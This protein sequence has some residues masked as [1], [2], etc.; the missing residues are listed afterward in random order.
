[1]DFKMNNVE[2]ILSQTLNLLRDKKTSDNFNIFTTLFNPYDE[3]R[4]HSR[5]IGSLLDPAPNSSHGMGSVFLKLFLQRI[6]D[7][8]ENGKFISIG[9]FKIDD[10]LMRLEWKNIDILLD[11]RSS[12]SCIIIEN[13]I[14]ASDQ[15]RQLYR[16]H[17]TMNSLG[18]KN[19]GILYLTIDGSEPSR[20]S[21]ENHNGTN[22][23]PVCIS[24][25]THILNWLYDCIGVCID[26]PPL[27]ESISQYIGVVK[28]ITGQEKESEIVKK[29]KERFLDED[30]LKAA[31]EIS[32]A[33]G[34]YKDEI[35]KGFLDQLVN[36]INEL[37]Q[38]SE[39]QC[40][41]EKSDKILGNRT[42]ATLS[43]FCNQDINL[44]IEL[45]NGKIF[46]GF[47]RNNEHSQVEVFLKDFISSN[48]WSFNT[49]WY[50][51]KWSEPSVNLSDGSA[52]NL[53]SL[54][55]ENIVDQ[56]LEDLKVSIMPLRKRR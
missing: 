17:Q 53:L 18:R 7:T 4:L 11:C 51:W 27:R 10:S 5:F 44:N 38:D 52:N 35:V 2:N 36:K 37:S 26:N 23:E 46:Y 28:L 9:T 50:G 49:P 56:I 12:K 30:C 20:Q 34:S 16:Y 3:V 31:H 15:E 39:L 55:S 47:R 42:L 41:C 48:A 14:L 21:V 24:Y 54:K 22:I 29:L 1:M 8:V 45:E 40:H 19:I 25:S 32:Q 13:K 33:Y 43:G 6:F